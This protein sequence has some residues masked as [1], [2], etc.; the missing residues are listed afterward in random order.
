MVRVTQKQYEQLRGMF[1]F[2]SRLPKGRME[3]YGDIE[4]G[5]LT[6]IPKGRPLLGI[7]R[8]WFICPPCEI[9]WYVD[10][11]DL[12]KNRVVPCPHC[13]RHV[14]N[15]TQAFGVMVL[16]TIDDYDRMKQQIEREAEFWNSVDEL[17]KQKAFS[18]YEEMKKRRTGRMR[19]EERRARI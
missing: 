6:V 16:D 12:R 18:P 2:P 1:P 9:A 7:S 14:R 8:M 19:E 17:E 5:R 3:A 13:E 15:H 10:D 4:S 11:L